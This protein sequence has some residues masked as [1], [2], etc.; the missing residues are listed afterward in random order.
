MPTFIAILLAIA[1]GILGILIYTILQSNKKRERYLQEAFFNTYFWLTETQCR[2]SAYKHNRES[3]VVEFQEKENGIKQI[4]ISSPS[5]DDKPAVLLAA[6]NINFKRVGREV[7]IGCSHVIPF[8]ELDRW[9]IN[10]DEWSPITFIKNELW[11]YFPADPTHK[12]T[13][14]FC[15]DPTEEVSSLSN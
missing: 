7:N 3:P 15:P 12:T 13:M 8:N 1:C 6:I 14:D 9:P 10:G 5:I 4:T 2:K 11:K